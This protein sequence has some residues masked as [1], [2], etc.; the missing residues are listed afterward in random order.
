[1]NV[2]ANEGNRSNPE[3]HKVQVGGGRVKLNK[4]EKFLE[5]RRM[6]RKKLMNSGKWKRPRMSTKVKQVK[7]T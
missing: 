4:G 5:H 3:N 7:K 6:L 1:M 2:P